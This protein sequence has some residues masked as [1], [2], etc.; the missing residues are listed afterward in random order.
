MGMFGKGL[1]AA[2]IPSGLG[3][4]W[5]NELV[6]PNIPVGFCPSGGSI[7]PPGG[8]PSGSLWYYPDTTGNNVV[9]VI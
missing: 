4:F 5:A 3:A 9:Y 2:T 6:V 1:T 8:Y 7:T